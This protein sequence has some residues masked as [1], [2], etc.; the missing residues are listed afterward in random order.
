MAAAM[1]VTEGVVVVGPG[2]VRTSIAIEDI[3][4]E[5]ITRALA[6]VDDEH[7]LVDDQPVAVAGLWREIFA[8][9]QKGCTATLL[10]CPTWWSEHRIATVSDAARCAVPTVEVVRRAVILASAVAGP[11]VVIE[12]AESLV[13]VS[14]PSDERPVRAVGRVGDP[15]TVAAEVVREASSLGGA[16]GAVVVDCP[17]GVGGGAELAEFIVDQLR[18]DGLAVAVVDDQSL[19][20]V[21][22]EHIPVERD[23]RPTGERDFVAEPNRRAVWPLAGGV[24]AAALLIVALTIARGATS[25]RPSPTLLV[26][27]RVVVEVPSTWT[28]RRITAAPG[29][30][31]VQVT[32][33]TDPQSALHVTQ[34]PVPRD[35]T[36][37]R[38]A[39]TLRQAM[40]AEQSGVFVDFNP[41]DRRGDRPAVTY[42]EIR[43]GHDIRWTVLL[44]GTVRISIGCQS[45]RGFRDVIRAVCERAVASARSTDELAGTIAPQAQSNHT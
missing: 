19:L 5:L 14:L 8:S 45:P 1:R 31:R 44:D 24:A 10:I 12:I 9:T 3:S 18:A 32:S 17:D 36:L 34:S 37:G 43:Y 2:S 11:S 16:R 41:A 29:S 28:A 7:A 13:V 6:C 42:R 26:E 27:G 15:L 25:T 20:D 33:P 39:D 38:T 21:A 30:A 23:Q 35:E 4:P 40:L 22:G